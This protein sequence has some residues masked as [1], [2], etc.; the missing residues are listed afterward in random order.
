MGFAPDTSAIADQLAG[1]VAIV[2]NYSSMFTT[3]A[4]ISVIDDMMAEMRAAGFDDVLAEVNR[5]YAEWVAAN[6]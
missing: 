1:L 6:K 4:D 2:K 5:Q 3:G